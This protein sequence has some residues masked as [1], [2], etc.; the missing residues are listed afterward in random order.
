MLA[1]S[2]SPPD[3]TSAVCL[4]GRRRLAW[5]VWMRAPGR[6]RSV[7]EG[8]KGKCNDD[9]QELSRSSP[10]RDRGGSELPGTKE[11]PQA[12]AT[13]AALTEDE[14]A[15][16]ALGAAI[17]QQAS[18]A[19]KAL[20]LTP[21]ERD[22]FQKGWSRRSPERS[23]ASRWSSTVRGCRRARRRKRA[24]RPRARSRSAPRSARR[25]LRSRARSRRLRVWCS[26]LSSR[27]RPEPQ[28]DRRRARALPRHSHRRY[29]VRQL[30]PAWRPRRV[31][32]QRR[33]PVLD[34]GPSTDEGR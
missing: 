13:A 23:R 32:A 27:A 22:V 11:K 10:R 18:Q 14:K 17:G 2:L 16:Y 25:R 31:P 34:R 20:K 3:S 6:D 1:A 21:A 5:H 9:S 8:R 15:V 30:G 19:V 24:W 12:G 28:G 26:G 4:A 29:G 33:H 7:R